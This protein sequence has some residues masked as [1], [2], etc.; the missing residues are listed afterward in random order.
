MKNR[1]TLI[2]L[3]WCLS[4]AASFLIGKR[5]GDSSATSASTGSATKSSLASS[6]TSSS[7]EVSSQS[8]ARSRLAAATFIRPQASKVEMLQDIMRHENPVERNNTLLALIETLSAEEFAGVVDA[9]RELGITDSRRGEYAMLLSA[10]ATIAPQ[11]AIA[12]AH[13]NTGGTFARNTILATWAGTNP[14]AALAWA[15]AN[16]DSEEANPWLV[17]VIRG[18]A[19]NNLERATG[20]MNE[21]Q[22]SRQRG[23]ALNAV[24]SLL[25]ARDPASAKEWASTVDDP[26]LRSAAFARTA[27]VLSRRDVAEAAN[28]LTSVGDI[29]ALNRAGDDLAEDW[30]EQ[31]PDAAMQWL[32]TL[33][34]EAL[35][36]AAEGIIDRM[37]RDNNSIEAASYLADI[38]RTNPNANYDEAVEELIGSSRRNDPQLAA[39]WVRALSSQNEQNRQYQRILGRWNAQNPE[40]VQDWVATNADYLPENVKRRFLANN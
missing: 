27:E 15:L 40:E 5:L 18:I 34:A 21:M 1:L 2:A 14:D 30:Y 17:G 13:E 6:S 22:R 20:I 33:P 29:E 36:S 4:L 32:T 23:A 3:F 39:E 35:G 26:T 24:V 28:W 8:S 9:F 11:E 12:Y 7:S 25:M 19:P 38:M 16:H 37:S 10:W 31:D